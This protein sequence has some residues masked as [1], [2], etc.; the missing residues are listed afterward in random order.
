[1]QDTYIEYFIFMAILKFEWDLTSFNRQQ[2]CN[3]DEREASHHLVP[4]T[5]RIIWR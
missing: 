2:A 3:A 1:M 5:F 4:S